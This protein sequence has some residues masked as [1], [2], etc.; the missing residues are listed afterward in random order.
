MATQADLDSMLRSLFLPLEVSAL[1]RQRCAAFLDR[2]GWQGLESLGD[3]DSI[4][5]HL[6]ISRA[7]ALILQA[8]I[9]L[10]SVNCKTLGNQPLTLELICDDL[11]KL[12]H[13]EL[14]GIYLDEQGCI[15]HAQTLAVGTLERVEIL[16]YA[17]LRPAFVTGTRRMSLA[18]NHPSQ[19]SALSIADMTAFTKLGRLFKEVGIAL[20]SLI[21]VTE[22]GISVQPI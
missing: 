18:H 10:Q 19:D 16:P 12:S 13:E 6:S 2:A 22:S 11:R 21:V 5:R 1:D 14:R 3:S 9:N 20:E 15:V 4:R 8:A 7:P 17:A